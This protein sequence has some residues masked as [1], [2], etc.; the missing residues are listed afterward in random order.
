MIEITNISE[1]LSLELGKFW[2]S[3]TLVALKLQ[4]WV[5]FK[6]HKACN[7]LICEKMGGVQLFVVC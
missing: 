2:V 4:K 7:V 3:D 5:N 6:S 1:S